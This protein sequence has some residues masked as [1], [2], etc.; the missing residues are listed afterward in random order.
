M[1][2]V[3]AAAM[4][5]GVQCFAKP[6]TAVVRLKPRV[7]MQM[8]AAQARAAGHAFTPEEIRSLSGPSDADYASTLTQLKSAGLRVLRESPTHLWITVKGEKAAIAKLTARRMDPARANGADLIA[9]ATGVDASVKRRHRFHSAA[10]VTTVP[11][12]IQPAQIKTVYGF[13]P[14]YAAGVDGTKMDIAVATYDAPN[15][16]DVNAFYDQTGLSPRPSVDQVQFNGA[17]QTNEDSAVET[18]LDASFSGMIAPGAS[19]HIF[20]SS[21]ND[22]SGEAQMFTAILDDNRA[23]VVNYSWGGCEPQVSPTHKTEMDEIFSRAVAQ[24]VNVLVAS[25]DNGSD[26]CQDGGVTP[27]WPAGNPN[28]VA[29]GGTTLHIANNKPNETAWGPCDA[30]ANL[31]CSG[32]GISGLY[33]LPDYQKDFKAP[34]VKRSYPDVAFNADNV[35]SGQAIY[36]HLNG[37]AGWLVVG[38]TSMAAPQWA[39]FLTLVEKARANKGEASLGFLNPKIYATMPDVRATLFNDVTEG[40]NG[41][42]NA[43]PGWDA[44]TGLGSMQANALLNFLLSN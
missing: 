19:V 11:G 16:D 44:V 36:T 39:G 15:L 18:T 6:V 31:G 1:K 13:D 9:A 38:G 25:G 22:D 34:Y 37:Q 3:Y 14:I 42:Y 8:L 20:A 4:L 28:V 10:T 7:S 23:K 41:A 30:N 5:I 26:S 17:P 24:G 32:G 29:V 43:G 35:N 33:D 21:T 27:D 12:G 2:W 40:T